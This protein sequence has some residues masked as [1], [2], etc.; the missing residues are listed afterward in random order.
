MGAHG[1]DDGLQFV[2]ALAVHAHF[3]ALDLRRHLELAV[4]D[5]A[6]DLLGHGALD[7]LLDLDALPRVAERR[8]VRVA[9]LD[10]LEADT[11]FGELADDHL[12]ERADLELVVGGELDLRFFQNDLPFAS[13]EIEAVGQFLFG[14]VDGVLDFHRVDLRNNV[15]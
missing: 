4:A 13:L 15:E 3:V 7:A 8:D 14:L 6:G 5:E 2:A 9:L 11:A 1:G 10:A 12:V